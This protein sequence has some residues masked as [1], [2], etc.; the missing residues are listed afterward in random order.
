MKVIVAPAARDYI[1]SEAAYLR[2]RNLQAAQQFSDNLKRLRQHLGQFPAIGHVT[3]EVIIPGVRRFVLG[4]YLVD[5]EIRPQTI[6][7]LAIRHGHQRPPGLALDD[8][9]DFEER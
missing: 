6:V 5:Y 8:D 9:F 7:I 2:Q 1:R 4:A 3:D